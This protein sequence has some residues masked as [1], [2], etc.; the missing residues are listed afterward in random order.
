[1]EQNLPQNP[2]QNSAPQMSAPAEMPMISPRKSGGSVIKII[3]IVV[4]LAVVGAGVALASRAWDPVWNPFRPN[5]GN[6]LALMIGK[7]EGVKSAHSETEINIDATRSGMGKLNLK[8]SGDSNGDPIDMKGIMTFQLSVS[9]NPSLSVSVKGEMRVLAGNVYFKISEIKAPQLDFMAAMYGM[10]LID[11]TNKWVIAPIGQPANPQQTANISQNILDIANASDVYTLKKQ[12]P[13][14]T[15]DGQPVYHYVLT[16]DKDKLI[17]TMVKIMD[18]V[19]RQDIQAGG[20]S[21]QQQ[22]AF[23]LDS[24]AVTG[25]LSQI[26]E[27]LGPIDIQ[28]LIGR[29]DYALYGTSL[30]KEIDLSKLFPGYIQNQEIIGLEIKTMNSKFGETVNVAVPE[31]FQVIEEWLPKI[32]AIR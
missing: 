11:M 30:S 21:A 14:Q 1:M 24:G 22:V 8:I 10:N 31:A 6:V 28:M 26:L 27:N 19:S 17:A 32:P 2:M 12:L 16:L 3:G 25:M 9:E 18:E 23:L 13:N 20:S 15:I 7:M 5:P 29:N 4:I